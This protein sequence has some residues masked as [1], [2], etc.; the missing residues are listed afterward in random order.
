LLPSRIWAAETSPNSRINLGFIGCG[1]QS[2]GLLNGFLKQPGTQTVAVCDVDTN[3]R[4]NHKKLTEDFY[5]KDG[6]SYKG[7]AVYTDFR[8]LLARK[9][10]DAVVIATPD[11]WHAIIGIAAAAA[12]KDIY[13]EKPLT[14]TIHEARA[15]VDAVRKNKRVVQTGSQQRSLREFRVA[16]ELVRNGVLGKISAVTAGFGG[17]GKMCD[18]AAEPM[19]PGLDWDMWLGPAP[20]RD[21]NETDTD[22]KFL[23][24]YAWGGGAESALCVN[25]GK[26]RGVNY[27]R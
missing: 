12:G 14:Q 16:C 15:L 27:F 4:E 11:H 9:D 18:L 20:M 23:F 3:R 19:E 24:A 13:C 25:H 21:Y 22:K 10:I 17:P 1:I 7:C 2:R 8:D 26:I 6:A 5:S